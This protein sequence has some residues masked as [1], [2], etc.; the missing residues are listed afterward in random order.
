MPRPEPL[1]D[2]RLDAA[3]KDT[4]RARRELHRA[5]RDRRRYE[6]KEVKRFTRR[7]RRRRVAWLVVVACF[8]VLGAVVAATVYSPLL[9]LTTVTVEGA[10]R[11]DVAQV[12][13]AVAPQLGRPLAMV[14][15][16]QIKK[17]LGAFPLIRSYV[18]ETRPPHTLVIKLSER[19]PI[20]LVPTASGFSV[21]DPA[22]VELSTGE[23]RPPG[24]PVISAGNDKPES[25]GFVAAVAVLLS[26]PPGLLARVDTVTAQTRDDVSLTLTDGGPTVVW[27]SSD[28]TALKAK[29]FADVLAGTPGAT[30][31][32]VSV[33]TNP[34]FTR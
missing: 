1:R 23:D 3:A 4:A 20:G 5:E 8:V 17:E 15:F 32:D 22:G 11:V 19:A 33:P 29:V 6:R 25:P 14:D 9:S 10:S 12:R 18:T 7:S 21:I 28:D 24:L 34:T 2:P 31:I 26:L 16:G 27:G 30:S 13:K